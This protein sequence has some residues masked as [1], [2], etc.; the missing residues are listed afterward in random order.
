[1]PAVVKCLSDNCRENPMT[2]QVLCVLVL[3]LGIPAGIPGAFLVC[4][5]V[6]EH[7]NTVV[8]GPWPESSINDVRVITQF[9]P[10]PLE[11]TYGLSHRMCFVIWVYRYW[12]FPEPVDLYLYRTLRWWWLWVGGRGR[13]CAR[14]IEE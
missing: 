2:K 4:M 5:S 3:V 12:I 7:V 9:R 11:G 14:L 10:L 13:C 1:M 8:K 6:P